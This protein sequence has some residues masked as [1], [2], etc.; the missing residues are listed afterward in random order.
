MSRIALA[1]AVALALVPHVAPA[2]DL[3][4]TDAE[5][6]AA[7]AAA[8]AAP[9]AESRG[10]GAQDAILTARV[11]LDGDGQEDLIGMVSSGYLC[12]GGGGCPIGVFRG[13]A[14]GF[15]YVTSV[16]AG[17]I[18]VLDTRHNGWRDLSLGS[19]TGAVIYV[20]TGSDYVMQ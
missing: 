1:S 8:F 12:G 6:Q 16:Y 2:L 3:V 19:Q 10:A 13:G 18:D 9:I 15:E 11:D 17:V 20:W 14:D 7:V 5:A 4:A